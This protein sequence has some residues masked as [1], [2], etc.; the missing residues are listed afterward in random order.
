[1]PK[2]LSVSKWSVIKLSLKPSGRLLL[3]STRFTGTFPAAVWNYIPFIAHGVG[4]LPTIF[5][6]S[7]TLRS[8]LMG[9]QLSDGPR[10]LATLTF[11]LGGHGLC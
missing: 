3:L 10:D 6:V 8:Q 11:N 9:Q 2:P 7:V 5:G 1:M 4:N